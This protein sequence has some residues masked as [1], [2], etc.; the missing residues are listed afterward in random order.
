MGVQ[1]P[2][3]VDEGIGDG[4]APLGSDELDRSFADETNAWELG[5][6]G[7][8]TRRQAEGDQPRSVQRELMKLHTERAAEAVSLA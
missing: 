7:S 2:E 6:D 5:E 1:R 4:D 8:W 3:Q